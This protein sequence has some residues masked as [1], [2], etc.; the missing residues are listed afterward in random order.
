M[1]GKEKTGSRWYSLLLL[2]LAACAG[3]GGVSLMSMGADTGTMTMLKTRFP[4]LTKEKHSYCR[5][6]HEVPARGTFKPYIETVTTRINPFTG[7]PFER[8]EAICTSCHTSLH[9]AHPVGIVPDP[10][11][12]VLPPEA[13]GFRGEENKLTCLG[14]HNHHP[15]NQNYKYLRWPTD[16]G[17]DKAKFCVHCHPKQGR[18]DARR[19]LAR[20][21]LQ[22]GGVMLP[23]R[24]SSRFPAAGYYYRPRQ[25]MMPTDYRISKRFKENLAEKNFQLG[26]NFLEKGEIEK[27]LTALG[28]AVEQ[29]PDHARAYHKLGNIMAMRGKY[30][31]AISNYK[32][33]IDKDPRFLDAYYDLGDAYLNQGQY[34]QAINAY[35]G[36]LVINPAHPG[37]YTGI[38]NA[39]LA[40]GETEKAL[41]KYGEALKHEP[42]H[43]EAHYG[44]GN[45]YLKLGKKEEAIKSFRK[46]VDH[47]PYYYQAYYKLGE[48]YYDKGKFHK[49]QRAYQKAVK[50]RYNYAEAY[51]GLG[52]TYRVMRQY[53]DAA[54][55]FRRATQLQ[56][57]FK[58]AFL[59]LARTC[60][61]RKLWKEAIATYKRVLQLDPGEVRAY[62][63]IGDANLGAGDSK[64]ALAA[65]RK[66]IELDPAYA[67]AHFQL[68]KHYFST[69]RWERAKEAFQATLEADE[70]HPQAYYYLGRTN[71]ARGELAEAVEAYQKALE[72]ARPA[73]RAKIYYNLALTYQ[74]M[75]EKEK[76]DNAYYLAVRNQLGDKLDE[77][78]LRLRLQDPIIRYEI[79]ADIDPDNPQNYYNLGTACI[80]EGEMQKAKQAYQKAVRLKP[81]Y[82]QAYY[83]LG[84]AANATKD[85]DTAIMAYRRLLELNPED[86]TPHYYLGIAY[87]GKEDWDKAIEHYKQVLE[88]KPV[89]ANYCLGQAYYEKWLREKKLGFLREA[90]RYLSRA[91]SLNPQH[92]EARSSL[93]AVNN[94]LEGK[95]EIVLIS[96]PRYA[97]IQDVYYALQANMGR[98]QLDKIVTNFPAKAEN[99]FIQ[100]S[101][102]AGV[103]GHELENLK[104]G[105]ISKIIQQKRTYYIICR[106][107]SL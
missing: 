30:Q 93:Y 64:A 22:W 82:W 15:D 29:N 13:R 34:R 41:Y 66:A 25:Q 27:A 67:P 36:V 71:H 68:G 37:A 53:S 39:Y 88:S 97:T 5:L 31:L 63:G 70:H 59:E 107:N 92:E 99:M 76:A 2:L 3:C 83:Y 16:G 89:Q 12:V 77:A 6:C 10:K 73:D 8:I 43:P 84:V 60:Q 91:L 56:P 94:L 18:R 42:K 4:D 28:K 45:V 69:G 87:K 48:C 55:A 11:K 7:K 38:G 20:E 90:S 95:V 49:A 61:D 80:T 86:K 1:S 24:S 78:A 51:Y 47:R 26:K 81:D 32:L 100:P 33:A 75:G 102:F 57:D 74:K 101:E 52:K 58:A 65:Y 35:E 23:S 46:A 50:L 105:Q 96:S 104:N 14:C 79:L 62:Q 19:L 21:K 98:E 85:Y 72:R 9:L 54:S 44:L 40:L 106:I 17:R 103:L